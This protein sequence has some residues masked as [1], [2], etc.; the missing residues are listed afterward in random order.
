M[1]VLGDFDR[2]LNVM[3]LCG[4][5]WFELMRA[6]STLSVHL[7]L[8]MDSHGWQRLKIPVLGRCGLTFTWGRG[9]ADS[10]SATGALPGCTFREDPFE[11]W[12]WTLRASLIYVRAY[13]YVYMLVYIWVYMYTVYTPMYVHVCVH[14]CVCT[15]MCVY[16]CASPSGLRQWI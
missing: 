5:R 4:R 13:T 2:I 12:K 3:A 9:W 10:F 15:C 11:N 8:W 6:Q 1:V 7:A 16:P 14:L